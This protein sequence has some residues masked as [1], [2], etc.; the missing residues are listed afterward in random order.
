ML[1]EL[2]DKYQGIILL[3]G[4]LSNHELVLIKKNVLLR[5]VKRLLNLE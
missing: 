5:N 3:H 1:V 4:K 2:R